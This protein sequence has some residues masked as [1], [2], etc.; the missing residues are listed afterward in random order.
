MEYFK[1]GEIVYLINNHGEDFKVKIILDRF[2][3]DVFKTWCYLVEP[4]EFE[5]FS[6][7]VPCSQCYK[8]EED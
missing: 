4:L 8:K 5:S 7:V 2:Y 6:R 1:K 3:D